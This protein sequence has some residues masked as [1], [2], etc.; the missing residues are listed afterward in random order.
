LSP[1]RNTYR[2]QPSSISNFR[3]VMLNCAAIIFYLCSSSA[4]RD[5]DAESTEVSHHFE[6]RGCNGV[7]QVC[8]NC[9]QSFHNYFRIHST[10]S[11]DTDQWYL[12]SMAYS[13]PLYLEK[14]AIK[15]DTHA[16]IFE[17]DVQISERRRVQSK[18][19]TVKLST[20]ENQ[21]IETVW[22]PQSLGKWTS[23]VDLAI[24][25][26]RRCPNLEKR[27]SYNRKWLQHNWT[28]LSPIDFTLKV[29]MEAT[30]PL[31]ISEN[32]GQ[33]NWK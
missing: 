17:K 20:F 19:N 7:N 2:G 25:I 29:A 24:H 4:P 13:V 9:A 33:N 10:F 12:R 8:S 30:V 18:M 6:F 23:V 3:E 22:R 15:R 27:V 28:Q 14:G 26:G 11:R 21:L 16:N 5:I 31:T 1:S 32:W